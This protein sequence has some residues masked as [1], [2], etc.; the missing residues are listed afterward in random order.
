[1]LADFSQEGG[2]V[3]QVIE[4]VRDL[5]NV[6]IDVALVVLVSGGMQDV[7]PSFSLLAEDDNQGV[8]ILDEQRQFQLD[9]VYAEIL[10][11]GGGVVQLV[12]VVPQVR[13]HRVAD[14]RVRQDVHQRAVAVHLPA[15]ADVHLLLPLH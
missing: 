6:E 3:E 13:L 14:A 1:M 4:G 8:K 15:L 2:V 12:N 7:V 11:D 10:L 5:L 9:D